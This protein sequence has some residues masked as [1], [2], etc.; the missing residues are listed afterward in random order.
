M[1]EGLAKLEATRKHME[2]G[3]WIWS[4]PLWG[5]KPPKSEEE[6]ATAPRMKCRHP[7]SDAYQEVRR[8]EEEA[9]RREN[10]YRSDKALD[11]EELLEVGRRA[12][13]KGLLLDWANWK[14]TDGNPF[15]YS[16]AEALK[17]LGNPL[18]FSKLIAAVSPEETFFAENLQALAGN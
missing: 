5:G 7:M 13:A 14:D 10:G 15:P 8:K 2:A 9:F 4:A 1:L 12:M 18:F 17:L 6:A 11:D 3:V 16:Q